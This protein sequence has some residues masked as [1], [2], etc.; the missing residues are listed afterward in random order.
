MKKSIVILIIILASQLIAGQGRYEEML[1]AVALSADGNNNEAAGILTGLINA[2]PDDELLLLRGDAYLRSG[3]LKEAK[4]D[5]MAAESMVQGSGLFGLARCAAAGGEARAAVSYLEAHLKSQFR[6]SEPEIMLDSSFAS[7]QASPEWKSLWKK[8]WYKGYERKSWEIDHYLK[9]GKTD[10]A[11]EVW[12][13]LSA[14]YADMPVTDFCKARI[15]TARGLYR[16]ASALLTPLAIKS[17]APATY[18]TALAAAQAGEGSY[19]AAAM[20]YGR[21]IDAEYPDPQLFLKRAA[22]LVKAGDRVA[23][24][25][26]LET[27]L[28]L[29]PENSEALGLIGKTYAEE[30]AIYEALPYLNMNIEKHPGEA[31]AFSIRGDAWLAARTWDKAAEDYTMSLDLDPENATVNLNLGIALINSGKSEDACHYLRKAKEQGNKD[32]T[33]YLSKYCIR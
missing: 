1:R 28:G 17:D 20:S 9:I 25:A 7:V 15:L 8:D 19:Y 5:F 24:K 2:A 18:I 23:A 11:E 4:S 21:L 33:K 32:A 31:T 27:Y 22:M 30:G 6:K 13:E 29:N 14:T 26:D 10:L 12:R 16:D 3:K